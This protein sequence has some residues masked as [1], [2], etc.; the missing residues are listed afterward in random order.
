MAPSGGAMRRVGCNKV[1]KPMG[2]EG[3]LV[4]LMMPPC[5]SCARGA[6]GLDFEGRREH[7]EVT[8]V[9]RREA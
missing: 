1:A 7:G 8:S 3:M 9:A 6:R 4:L 5:P 2:A